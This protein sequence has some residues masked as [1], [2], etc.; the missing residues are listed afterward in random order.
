MRQFDRVTLVLLPPAL[1]L[2][3]LTVWHALTS[4]VAPWFTTGHFDILMGKR[5]ES[6]VFPS[7]HEFL[8]QHDS[9]VSRL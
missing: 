7:I 9:P 4:D 5:V 8:E 1:P 3:Y 2:D 6:E